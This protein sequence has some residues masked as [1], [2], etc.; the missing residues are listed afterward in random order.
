MSADPEAA[1]LDVT[2]RKL[3]GHRLFA[4]T[5]YVY[6]ASGRVRIVRDPDVD[7][8]LL[9][10]DEEAWG[11]SVEAARDRLKRHV[12]SSDEND[13]IELE[14]MIAHL[15]VPE[16][17]YVLPSARVMRSLAIYRALLLSA[18][19]LITAVQ[20]V[21]VLGAKEARHGAIVL[22]RRYER[23]GSYATILMGQVEV[24]RHLQRF[25]LRILSPENTS[26]FP[27]PPPYVDMCD[28]VHVLRATWQIET[29][30][31]IADVCAFNVTPSPTLDWIPFN[32]R[33][34]FQAFEYHAMRLNDTTVACDANDL[35]HFLCIDL[36]PEHQERAVAA[37]LK[38]QLACLF[39]FHAKTSYCHHDAAC[40]N[41]VL[42][43][44]VTEDAHL[45]SGDLVTRPARAFTIPESSTRVALRLID[46]DLVL[47]NH[48][49]AFVDGEA[50]CSKHC[51]YFLLDFVTCMYCMLEDLHFHFESN[52]ALIA[53]RTK[54][55]DAV[56]DAFRAWLHA[57]PQYKVIYDNILSDTP[58]FVMHD[59]ATRVGA[60]GMVM[61][62]D[63]I[64]VNNDEAYAMIETLLQQNDI[65][66]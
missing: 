7:R 50:F 52:T 59:R 64:A 51:R 55:I 23:K 43:E 5:Y 53:L 36:A 45:E 49:H 13:T 18:S 61:K 24:R 6:D 22:S 20:A 11:R 56:R 35:L 58:R 60:R 40:R 27:D 48:K 16:P 65:H 29:R 46:F 63:F 2:V 62:P 38:V 14:D 26:M 17:D 9:R 19:D 31:G 66:T 37:L 21:D 39:D 57:P 4:P 41:F 25:A 15:L 47:P 30:D 8:L 12:E 54:L 32:R 42:F 28:F 33:L 34:A 10:H 1:S 44:P 3:R